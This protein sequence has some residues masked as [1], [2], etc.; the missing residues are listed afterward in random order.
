MSYFLYYLLSS[1]IWILVNRTASLALDNYRLVWNDEFDGTELDRS[2]WYHLVDCSGRGNREL[3]CYTNRTENVHV[4]NGVLTLAARP[5]SFGNKQFT[6]GRVHASGR[7]WRFGRFE[8]RAKLPKGQHLWPAIWLVPTNGVYGPWPQSGEIDIMEQRGQNTTK[9]EGT[10]HFGA[11][12]ARRAKRGSGQTEFGFDFSDDFHVFAFEW[13]R[14]LMIWSVD[15]HEFFSVSL[16]RSFNVK[17]SQSYTKDGSPF[18]QMFKWIL[19][20]A[21]GGTYFPSSVYGDIKPESAANWPRPVMEV[22]WVRVYQRPSETEDTE[23]LLTLRIT[24]TTSTTTSQPPTMSSRPPTTSTTTPTP[25]VMPTTSAITPTISGVSA[26][27]SDIRSTLSP[28]SSTTSTTTST[29]TTTTVSPPTQQLT[30]TV[31]SP[32][33]PNTE[34]LDDDY[35]NYVD[36]YYDNDNSYNNPNN[37]N[38]DN[39]YYYN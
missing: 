26:N 25:V 2:K 35:K 32:Y 37:N 11:S 29:T 21:V 28:S 23:G 5:E 12:R 16:R 19:N 6:S 36:Y 4:A 27:S 8:T 34:V 3:Q 30:T 13:T 20:V 24:T 38:P 7:G 22:D 33:D 18:D 1:I 17:G 9:V 15:N 31:S 39:T 14:D 10:L